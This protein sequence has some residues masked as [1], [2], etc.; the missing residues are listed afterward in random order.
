[1]PSILFAIGRIY[2]NQFNWND[3]KKKKNFLN[4]L[5]AYMK[6]T[7]NGPQLE[8]KMTFKSYVFSKLETVNYVVS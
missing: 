7:S 2:R 5:A 1:M 6:S 4:F 3:L 8:K